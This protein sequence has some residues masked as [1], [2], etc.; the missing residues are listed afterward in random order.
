[1]VV[2]KLGMAC[3]DAGGDSKAKSLVLEELDPS[4]DNVLEQQSLRWVFVGGK[5]GVGKTT[6]RYVTSLL[7]FNRVFL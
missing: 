6:C 3:K 7:S 1:M 5:G 2:C 4:L